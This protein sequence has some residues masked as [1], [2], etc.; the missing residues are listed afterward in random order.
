M[1]MLYCLFTPL[2]VNRKKMNAYSTRRLVAI[3]VNCELAA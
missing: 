2:L 3:L 1:A